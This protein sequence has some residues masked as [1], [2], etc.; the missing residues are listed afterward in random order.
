LIWQL[1]STFSLGSQALFV[2]EAVCAIAQSGF[3]HS[4][5]KKSRFMAM[6]DYRLTNEPMVPEPN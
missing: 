6:L 4:R 2:T 1:N 5:I 3:K